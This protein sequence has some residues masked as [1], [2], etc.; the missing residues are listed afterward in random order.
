MKITTSIV[1]YLENIGKQKENEN[2]PEPHSETPDH[3]GY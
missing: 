2:L 3:L 1:E